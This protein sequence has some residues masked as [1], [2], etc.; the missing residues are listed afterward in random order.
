MA[1]LAKNLLAN[2]GDVRDVGSVTGSRT[3]GEGNSNPPQ[4]SCPEDSMDGGAWWATV[5]VITTSQT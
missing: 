1:Q 3:P 2:A 5:H 4:Y